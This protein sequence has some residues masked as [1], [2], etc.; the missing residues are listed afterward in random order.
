MA[1]QM[2][3][4]GA[5]RPS[6]KSMKTSS[7]CLRHGSRLLLELLPNDERCLIYALT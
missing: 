1:L 7:S 4:Q 5:I 3:V 2:E 6:M